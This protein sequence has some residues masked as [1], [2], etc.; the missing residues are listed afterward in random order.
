MP[1]PVNLKLTSNKRLMVLFDEGRPKFIKK[2]DEAKWRARIDAHRS[3]QS[4]SSP[5]THKKEQEVHM[6]HN[7]QSLTRPLPSSSTNIRLQSHVDLDYNEQDLG[8]ILRGMIEKA[9]GCGP[10]PHRMFHEEVKP[11]LDPRTE[12]LLELGRE[13]F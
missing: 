10:D 2:A 8:W 5:H 9:R 7:S 3:Q 12:K 4:T 11:T 13:V 1:N 6:P